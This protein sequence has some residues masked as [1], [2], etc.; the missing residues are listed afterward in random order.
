[1]STLKHDAD[2]DVELQTHRGVTDISQQFDGQWHWSWAKWK[3]Y[4]APTISAIQNG[5][6]TSQLYFHRDGF[7]RETVKPKDVLHYLSPTDGKATKVLVQATREAL[8]RPAGDWRRRKLDGNAPKLLRLSGWVLQELQRKEHGTS[9]ASEWTTVA[10]KALVVAPI[11]LFLVGF[12]MGSS[13]RFL[14]FYKNFPGKC[15]E[16]PKYAR[17][18]LLDGKPDALSEATYKGN[19]YSFAGEYIRQL[20]PRRLVFL[21]GD[22]AFV[23]TDPSTENKSDT[24][25]L[26]I[27]YTREHFDPKNRKTCGSLYQVAERVTREAGLEAYWLDHLCITQE[28]GSEQSEDI[29]RISDVIRGARQVVVVVPDLQSATLAA[30][31]GRM[32][33]LPEALLC[34]NELIKFCEPS[35]RSIEKS[36]ITLAD[37]VW[38]GDQTGRLLAENFSGSLSLGRLE[39]ISKGLDALSCRRTEH[40]SDADLAYALMGLLGHRPCANPTDNEFQALARLSL[41]NDSDRIVE[42]MMC[43]LPDYDAHNG[44][45]RYNNKFVLKD[46][47]GANLWDIEP[48]CQ[49][50]GVCEGSAVILD[51]CRG[52]SIRWKDIPEIAYL[53]RLTWKRLLLGLGLRSGGLWFLIGISLVGIQGSSSGGIGAFCLILGLILTFSSPWSISMIYG[54][55]VWGAAPWLIGFEGTLPI[56]DIERMTF[57]TAIGRFSY[58]PSSSLWQN[59]ERQERIGKGPAWIEKSAPKPDL[60]RGQRFFTLIDTGTMTVNVFAAEKPP[61]VALIVGREGGMLRVA[62]CHYERSTATLFKETVLRMETPMLDYAGMFTHR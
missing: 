29:N 11:Q 53:R 9:T 32:W 60:P 49:V 42:R 30:W 26:L 6:T 35:G 3:S 54:G 46:K 33:T 55:K 25:Y 10:C 1:M 21:R 44:T 15:W 57:G 39:L 37:E 19:S 38:R 62:L 47:L 36:R 7:G 41:A 2:S 40:F 59:K 50:A 8:S 24:P 17:N 48:I 58:A 16:H 52:A 56:K 27:S 18:Q 43:M 31:G 14:Q 20:R 23:E 51:G 12:P 28:R 34:Q 45:S 5:V 22:G 13:P 4:T 61:S